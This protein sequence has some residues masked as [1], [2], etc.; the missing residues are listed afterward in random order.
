GYPGETEEEFSAL[1][2]FV[3]EIRPLADEWA[4]MLLSPSVADIA[5]Q[6]EGLGLRLWM[7]V[8]AAP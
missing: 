7:P 2:E 1:L 6:I 3:E 4:A 5:L 8:T